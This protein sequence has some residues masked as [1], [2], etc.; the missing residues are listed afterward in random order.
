M[1]KYLFTIYIFSLISAKRFF[2]N[3][4]AIFFTMAFPLIFL[5]VIG[6][7]FSGG[8]GASFKVVSVNQ[9]DSQI[10]RAFLAE[11]K[12]EGLV[13]IES[14]MQTLEGAKERLEKG[15]LSAVLFIP[16][17]FGKVS[18]KKPPEG[19][20]LVY[21]TQ[22]NIQTGKTLSELLEARLR[23]VNQ[24]YVSLEKPFTVSLQAL[25]TRGLTAFDYLFAGIL[26]F[27][28]IGLGI[29]GPTNVF[30]E[31]KKQGILR[32]FHTTPLRVSQFFISTAISRSIEG[33]F[34]MAL[35]FAVGIFVFDVSIAGSIAFLTL[36][37]FLSILMI[38]GIGL[39]LGGWARNQSQ[40]AP[41]SNLVV[42]PMIFLSGTFIPRYLMPEWLQSV[43]VYLPLTPV[44][45]GIRK[46]VTQG[47]TV[48]ELVP[49]LY[50][51]VGWMVI[52]YLVAFRVFRWE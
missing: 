51:I 12:N 4:L 8:S 33:L 17:D 35:L 28:I 43:S 46:I 38:L 7:I 44:I 22:N 1:K 11:I 19:E 10:A 50:L 45:E 36:W 32:R 20:I 40:V 6:G 15:D 2:R 27:S 29:F 5:L 23:E 47:A 18:E 13:E 16:R 49:E 34:A 31:L 26:G 30:P 25:E 41:L 21:T 42:F 14:K 3:R 48:F 24:E 37:I 52:I 39:A 9:S